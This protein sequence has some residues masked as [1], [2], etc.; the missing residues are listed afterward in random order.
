[1]ASVPEAVLESIVARIPV[2]RLGAPEEVAYV[3]TS[4][5]DDRASYVTG[6][7]IPVNGDST[8]DFAWT[9]SIG[10]RHE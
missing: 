1:M 8:C 6:A 10:P 4:L 3:V 2:A 5:L 7:V 9:P